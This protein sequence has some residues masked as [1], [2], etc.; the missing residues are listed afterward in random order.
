M[1]PWMHSITKNN[2]HEKT[3]EMM[4]GLWGISLKANTDAIPQAAIKYN[5]YQGNELPLLLFCMSWIII[6]HKC[7]DDNITL[8]RGNCGE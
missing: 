2:W 8:W 6:K 7:E 5:I 3:P 1:G 4:K